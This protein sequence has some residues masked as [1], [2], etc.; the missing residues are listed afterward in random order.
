MKKLPKRFKAKWLK[1][2]RSG[3]Y[4]QAESTLYNGV[5]GYC[6]LG[7]GAVVCGMLKNE[8][9]NYGYIDINSSL[10]PIIKQYKIPKQIIGDDSNEIVAKLSGFNDKGLSFK[11]IASY[12]ERYL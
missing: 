4:D 5:N 8:I 11:W 7:V 10:A 1:A 9:R 12:I 6:C 2:L 3:E